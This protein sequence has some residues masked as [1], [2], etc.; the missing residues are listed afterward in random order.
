MSLRCNAFP[1]APS[2]TVHY[3]MM[4]VIRL[5]SP[6]TLWASGSFRAVAVVLI[7]Q[8]SLAALFSFFSL[9]DDFLRKLSG[10]LRSYLENNF[11]HKS[12]ALA[13]FCIMLRLKK[14]KLT[15][16]LWKDETRLRF[17]NF[18][19]CWGKQYKK[20]GGEGNAAS[21][22]RSLH[23]IPVCCWNFLTKSQYM[24]FLGLIYF[25]LPSV[26]VLLPFNTI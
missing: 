24:A 8:N 16:T 14:N 6:L 19:W 15:H 18:R 1:L 4:S 23:D 2:P 5:L 21:F 13:F 9:L 11:L 7:I 25:C 3:E 26:S 20:K 22:F 17:R 10:L 12:F